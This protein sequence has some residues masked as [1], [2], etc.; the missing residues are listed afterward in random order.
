MAGTN[1]N[2]FDMVLIVRNDST[3]AWKDGTYRL[4]KGELGIGYLE[5]GHVIVKC[6]QVD[7]GKTTDPKNPVMKTW[8]ECPQVE[9]VFEDNLTLTYAFGKYSPDSTGSFELK[10]KDKTMS[11]VML[12]AFAQEVYTN[13]I[14]GNPSATFSATANSSG[15]VGT[16][17]GKPTATLDLTISGTYKYGAKNSSGTTGQANITATEA[18]ITYDGNVVAELD[19]Q[20]PNADLS[21]T[22]DLSGDKLVYQDTAEKYTFYATA[23]TGADVNRPLTNLGNFVAKDADGNYYGTKD[24]TAAIGQIAAKTLVNNQ[25]KSTTYTGYRNMFMGRTTAAN[26][27]VDSAFIRGTTKADGTK[28]TLTT[29]AKAEKKSIEVTAKANDTA[30]YYAYPTALTSAAPTFHYFIA[31]EWKPLSGPVLLGTNI[32][33]EGA[34]GYTAKPYTVYKYSPNSGIFEGEM[35]TKITIN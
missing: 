9:G 22:V 6:G 21:Y 3:T 12:D 4:E 30:L 24:F 33:V 2:K 16:T 32:N 34:N 7:A 29:N 28:L 11:E 20:N 27:T 10:T 15:E 14:T 1:T 23:K 31:N 35:K 19:E 5:N 25:E 26:P 13:L 8:A 17:H 18:S